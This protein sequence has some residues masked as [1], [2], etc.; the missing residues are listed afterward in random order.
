MIQVRGNDGSRKL[1]SIIKN[2]PRATRRGIRRAFYFTG[3]SLVRKAR[4]EIRRPGRTG[5]TYLVRRGQGSKIIRHKA[6]A[7]GE[8]PANL[9]GTLAR[10]TD[11]FVR[12]TT[13]LYFGSTASY[14]PFLELEDKLYRPFLSN[15]IE[16]E[17]K[18]TDNYFVRFIGKE[19]RNESI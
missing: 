11:F 8:Y 13:E 9:T 10:S 15:T 17:E 19:L 14:A 6:S 2:H 1:L 12:G 16:S 4:S 5:R 18:N 3:R 7:R